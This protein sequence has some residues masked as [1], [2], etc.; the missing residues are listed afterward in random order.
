MK[1]DPHAVRRAAAVA[2][3]RRT[4]APAPEKRLQRVVR[5]FPRAAAAM[6]MGNEKAVL[7]RTGKNDTGEQEETDRQQL[8]HFLILSLK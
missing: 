7:A 5:A 2:F 8:T 6:D 4:V 1:H 3:K